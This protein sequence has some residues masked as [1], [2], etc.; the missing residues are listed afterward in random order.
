[1]VRAQQRSGPAAVPPSKPKF[2]KHPKF[3]NSSC[4]FVASTIFAV[5]CSA[6]LS[7]ALVLDTAADHGDLLGVVVL[8]GVG[9]CGHARTNDPCW[10]VE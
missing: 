7:I 6:P 5:S 3:T 9:S 8:R 4:T 2:T 1:M 10:C